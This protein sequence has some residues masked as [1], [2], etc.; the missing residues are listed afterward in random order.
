LTDTRSGSTAATREHALE[1]IRRG[2]AVFLL[3]TD[4]PGGKIPYKACDRCS[5]RGGTCRDGR[6]CECLLCHAFYSATR[7]PDRLDAM[8]RLHP[9][10]H[11]AVRTGSASRLLVI[12]A[13][14]RRDDRH[15]VTGTDVVDHWEEWT[16]GCE[17]PTTLTARSVSGGLHLYYGLE[18]NRSDVPSLTRVLPCVDVKCEGGLVGAVGSR[19]SRRAWVNPGVAVAPA[20]PELLATLLRLRGRGGG[21]GGVGDG[22]GGGR[23][24]GYD[25]KQFEREGCPDGHRDSFFNDLLFRLRKTG[26]PLGRATSVAYEHWSRCAQPPEA[27]TRCEWWHVEY[28]IERVW[29]DVAPDEDVTHAVDLVARWGVLR[30]TR[31]VRP[32]SRNT[33]ITPY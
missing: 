14:A 15:G 10:G 22:G 3:A 30:E 13:E 8:L 6:T 12:D 24:P 4:G 25:F 18:P 29:G 9:D 17:L 32:L 19:S 20:S 23:S 1:H 27:R 2:W 16:N 21:Y 5:P 11:L 28:K 33:Q 31:G 26:T 7:D